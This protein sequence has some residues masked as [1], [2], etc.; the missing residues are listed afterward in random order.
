MESIFSSR[1]TARWLVERGMSQVFLLI[2]FLSL[3]L[4][5]IFRK[6]NILNRFLEKYSELLNKNKIFDT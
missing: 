2:S 6:N 1:T 5:Q 4:N 3:Y